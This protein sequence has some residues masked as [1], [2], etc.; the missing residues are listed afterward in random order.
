LI[1]FSPAPTAPLMKVNAAGGTAEPLTKL[2]ASQHTSHRWPVL[3]PDG[4]H[5]LYSAINHDPAKAGNDALYYA[6]FDGRENR[7]L[8]RTSSNALY[9][10]GFLLFAQGS[11]LMAQ[12]FN[13]A[14]GE[15]KGD[16]KP[17]A[18][19]VIKDPTTW[20]MDTSVAENGLLV[21]GSGAIGAR[22]LV[23][24]DRSGKEAGMVGN[25]Y[26]MRLSPQ[27]DKV[28]VR[29]D[30]A[31]VADI[32]VLDLERGVKTRLTFGPV[33]NYAPTWS[34]DGKC[35]Y[36]SSARNGRINMFRRAADGSS[37]EEAV[38][39]GNGDVFPDSFTPD[40]KVLLFTQITD[41]KDSI[42]SCRWG[43][44]ASRR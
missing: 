2:D 16:P 9:A 35:I 19:G 4:K 33:T 18:N 22:Q 6:S 42:W 37:A 32:W 17:I 26:G 39:A 27:G 40:G 5:F 15:L 14:K 7:L 30:I 25:S 8:L 29:I 13:P 34:Q 44:R 38:C 24:L 23:W 31:G 36:C 41:G 21:F 43:S 3:L 12:S 28:A 20:H 11:T 1:V 10:G